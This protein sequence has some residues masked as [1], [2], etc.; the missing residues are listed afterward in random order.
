MPRQRAQGFFVLLTSSNCFW[1]EMSKG[2]DGILVN[3]FGSAA[4]FDALIVFI[5]VGMNSW[6]FRCTWPDAE[7]LSV[8][9]V[10]ELWSSRLSEL[11][12]RLWWSICGRSDR[13]FM[14]KRG[15]SSAFSWL[16]LISWT[17]SRAVGM[18][19]L[20][21]VAA[22]LKN[23][24]RTLSCHNIITRRWY[25][26]LHEELNFHLFSICARKVRDHY[27]DLKLCDDHDDDT[28]L[29]KSSPAC[30]IS[31]IEPWREEDCC[32][33]DFRKLMK[34]QLLTVVDRI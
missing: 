20:F 1:A 13:L 16:L 5:R 28:H 4:G 15:W 14:T 19:P 8:D 27:D 21:P 10:V 2:F 30:M 3:C 9:E 25:A 17:L 22:D 12:Y 26:V 7:L 6:S 23:P 11:R 33:P 18:L 34:W 32:N 29:K 31:K 24:F